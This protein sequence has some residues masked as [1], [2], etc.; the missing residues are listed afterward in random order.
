MPAAELRL[1]VGQIEAG[2]GPEGPR[3]GLQAT[4][5]SFAPVLR[6]GHRGHVPSIARLTL[7]DGAGS[8]AAVWEVRVRG[9]RKWV[10]CVCLIE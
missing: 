8:D 5:R 2:G 4:L 1:T 10:I 6:R 3:A 7:E 9:G